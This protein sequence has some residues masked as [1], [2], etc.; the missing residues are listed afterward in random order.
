MRLSLRRR[1]VEEWVVL[2]SAIAIAP[3]LEIVA[4]EVIL[5]L[6]RMAFFDAKYDVR[7]KRT[8]K[9]RK[10]RL[11]GVQH[12]L[13]AAALVISS[14]LFPFMKSTVVQSWWRALRELQSLTS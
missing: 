11:C 9:R 6:Q 5:V 10:L 3:A 4:P 8:R 12:L 7:I 13:R 14:Y 2:W 1:D